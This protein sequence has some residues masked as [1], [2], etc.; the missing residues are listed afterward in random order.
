[1]HSNPTSFAFA[2]SL[3]H[4]AAALALAA[5]LAAL[6]GCDAGPGASAQVVPAAQ[7][8]PSSAPAVAPASRP[9]TRAQVF[10]GVKQMTALG[11]QLFVDPSLSGSGKLA[12]ASCHSA[13][14]AFGPPNALSVQLGG[15]DMRRA[16]FRAVPSLKY[17]R[18]IPPFSEHFHDSPD[19]GDESV[20]AGPTGG[21][22]WDGR[23]DTRDAQARIPLTSPFEMSSSPAK[24]AK[25]VRAA[26]YVDAFRKAFGDKVLADDQATFD[27]VLRALDAFQQQPALFDP[28][29]SKYDAYLAGK[30][31]LTPAELRGLQ[32]FNDERKGNCASCHL[33]QRTLEGGPPQFSDF[34]LI[35]IGVPRNRALPVNRDPRFYD[36]GACGPERTDLKGRS[37]FCGLFRTPSLRNVATR[38]TFFHNGVYH[39][40]EDVMRF[41]VERDIHPEK[42]YPVVH[43]KVQ[44]FDDLPK[45]YWENINREPPFDRKPGDQPALNEAEIKDV[46][47]F[48]NTLTDGYRAAATQASR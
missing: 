3:I 17:L 15:D 10:E 29:T 39:S 48:L 27:A 33:S 20:D 11:K 30:A 35:A 1:M 40:L 9:Q 31:Q 24:V 12:C 5:G 21:L 14:H 37:E 28:Y 7:A 22:T 44:R 18:G 13:E 41:Y 23:V 2:R 38:K 8:A 26:P 42:F 46:I 45:R 4:A 19:E 36:L 6:A 25:A 43:G 16:G 32:L 47:A 34:G